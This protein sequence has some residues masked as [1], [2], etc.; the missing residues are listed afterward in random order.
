[1]PANLTPDFRAAEE[2]YQKAES[3]DEKI[4][5][6]EEMLAKVP[7]HK[8]TEKI[9]ADIKSKLAKAKKQAE[10][11]G[12][13]GPARH[14]E[15]YSIPREGAGRV[16]LVGGPNT[17]KSRLFA[18]LTGVAAEVQ[19][20]AFTTRAPQPGMMPFEDVAVQLIDLPAVSR[21]FMESW[22]PQLVRLADLALLVVDVSSLDPARQAAEPIEVLL[23]KKVRLVP[24]GGAV[25][26]AEADPS[27]SVVAVPTLLVANCMD[28]DGAGEVLELLLGDLPAGFPLRGASAAAG[29][30]LDEMRRAVFD[31]LDVTRI[32]SKQP[33]KKVETAPFVVE[34]GTTTIAFAAKVHR[35]F[36]ERFQF[37]RVWR[38]GG[39][40]DGLRVAKDFVLLDG[41][42]VELHI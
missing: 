4:A 18:A 7:K 5:A 24:S 41:D 12:A 3:I 27:C 29:T 35:D 16:V 14:R 40:V 22:V 1:M 37:A 11:K 19:G 38:R 30:G 33:G 10:T 32:Y 20:Y 34:S 2:R 26:P 31:A 25:D 28:V 36:A 23:E 9:Q 17:G 21:Q 13:G 15:T 42:V 39:E 8:G 6:L